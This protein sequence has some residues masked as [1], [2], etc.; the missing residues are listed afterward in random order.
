MPEKINS[1]ICLVL[2]M[3]NTAEIKALLS[4]TTLIYADITITHLSIRTLMMSIQIA[5]E[6]DTDKQVDRQTE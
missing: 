6:M 5:R 2:A 3:V 1:C 4:P